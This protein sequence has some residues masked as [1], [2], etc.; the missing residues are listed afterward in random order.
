MLLSNITLY[1]KKHL[2][3]FRK[4]KNV[5]VTLV[6]TPPH[7]GFGPK[8]VLFAHPCPN[9]LTCHVLFEWPSSHQFV[10]SKISQ[11]FASVLG[12][13]MG[14]NSKPLFHETI[15]YS[16]SKHNAVSK[17][18][19]SIKPFYICNNIVTLNKDYSFV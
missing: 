1:I 14:K 15:K 12:C 18:V 10:G 11:H 16:R 17:T 4:T 9:I 5:E 6:L 3:Q 8:A 19:D 7:L 2:K 13:Q